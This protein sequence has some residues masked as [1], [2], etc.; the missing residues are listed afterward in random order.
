M[1]ATETPEAGLSVTR[2]RLL[3]FVGWGSFAAFWGS[4]TDFRYDPEFLALIG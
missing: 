3:S 4:I 1:H 2:R